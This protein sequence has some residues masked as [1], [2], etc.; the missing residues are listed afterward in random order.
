MRPSAAPF[1]PQLKILVC[2]E[3]QAPKHMVHPSLPLPVPTPR[4]P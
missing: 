2:V 4:A 3:H 1:V